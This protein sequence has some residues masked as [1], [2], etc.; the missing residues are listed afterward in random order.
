MPRFTPYTL[1]M[2]ITRMF[3]DGQSLFAQIKVN[4]WLKEHN[5]DPNDYN[6]EFEQIP[7]PPGSAEVYA[8]AIHVERKDGE[9]VEEWLLEEINR[10]G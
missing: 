8:I 6:I 10:Q 2:Q 3:Q 1:Q 7:A 5:Q 4:D 9:P